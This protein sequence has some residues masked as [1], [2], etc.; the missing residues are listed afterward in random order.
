MHQRVGVA[1][2]VDLTPS[3]IVQ[4]AVPQRHVGDVDPAAT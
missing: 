3:K 2:I 1:Q 4:A